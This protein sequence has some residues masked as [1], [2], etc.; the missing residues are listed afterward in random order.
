MSRRSLRPPWVQDEIDS[1]PAVHLAGKVLGRSL[2]FTFTV[3][4]VDPETHQ[5]AVHVFFPF[6]LQ[7]KTR[8]TCAPIEATHC[9]V[10][11][12]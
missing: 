2:Q 4:G 1:L 5:L 8:I 9:R 12:G 6:G 3:E 7:E 11:Y 10:Q